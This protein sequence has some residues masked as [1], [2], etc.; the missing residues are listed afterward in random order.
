MSM[1]T[2]LYKM[3]NL[4]FLVVNKHASNGLDLQKAISNINVLA[5]DYPNKE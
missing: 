3:G 1:M 2:K 5:S 4:A